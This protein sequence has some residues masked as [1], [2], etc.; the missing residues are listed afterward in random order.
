MAFLLGMCSCYLFYT[1]YGIASASDVEVSL[2]AWIKTVHRSIRL[3]TYYLYFFLKEIF[4]GF[5]VVALFGTFLGIIIHDSPIRYGL[6][7]FAGAISTNI[8][9]SDKY[10]L[11][12]AWSDSSNLNYSDY[13]F[14]YSKFIFLIWL[15]LFI[16]MPKFELFFKRRRKKR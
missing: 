15:S 13:G 9:F 12:Q 6:V 1:L 11:F 4:V 3:N 16:A 7:S 5:L 10:K 2:M 8:Y 14:W